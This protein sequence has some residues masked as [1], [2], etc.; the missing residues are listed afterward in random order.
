MERLVGK[1]GGK[2][3]GIWI[4]QVANGC[5]HDIPVMPRE[6][7]VSLSPEPTLESFTRY[8]ENILKYLNELVDEIYERVRQSGYDFRTVGVKLVRSDFSIETKETS[9][10]NFQNKRKSIASVIEGLLDRFS[11]FDS[12]TTSVTAVRKVGLKISNLV[13]IEKKKPPLEQKTLLDY[14]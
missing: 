4:W 13:R 8:R 1:F 7:H 3:N 5:D 11:F 9:F 2:K 12:T 14:Y 6:D 10:P